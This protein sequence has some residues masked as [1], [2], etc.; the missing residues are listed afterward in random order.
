MLALMP[1][2]QASVGAV[3]REDA[4]DA[5]GLY[6]MARNLGGSL[7]LAA[8]GVFIDRRVELHA[9]SIRAAVDANAPLVQERL[10]GMAAGFLQSGTDSAY[11]HRQ[12]L[13]ALAAQIHVQ[14]LVMTY[15]DCFWLLGIALMASLPLVLLLASPP[16]RVGAPTDS[17]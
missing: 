10:A 5:A 3:S 9:D 13:G 17:H 7:G 2:N 11:A 14:A 6:N 12:A 16:A 15:S 1:L 4:A 8:L